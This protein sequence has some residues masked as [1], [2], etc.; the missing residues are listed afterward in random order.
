MVESKSNEEWERARGPDC[1]S[2]G[3]ET[4]RLLDGVCPG[5]SREKVAAREARMED[6]AERK[7]V[8]QRFLAGTISARE[9]KERRY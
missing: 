5:C 1:P 7:Y 9:L 3:Q 4:L 2:C 8:K 6:Q